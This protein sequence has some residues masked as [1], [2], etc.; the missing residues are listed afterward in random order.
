[1]GREGAA[2]RWPHLT[3]KPLTLFLKICLCLLI[4]PYVPVNVGYP[5]EARLAPTTSV[6]SAFSTLMLSLLSASVAES[7]ASSYKA[8]WNKWTGFAKSMGVSYLPSAH[9]VCQCYLGSLQVSHMIALSLLFCVHQ[10]YVLKLRATSICGYL[11][12][13]AF[14]LNLLGQ[15]ASFLAS[16]SLES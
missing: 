14:N 2:T 1:V 12:G 8:G 10:F 4:Y 6:I 3:Y 9:Q 16:P 13:I 15:D 5:T 7:T 11:S